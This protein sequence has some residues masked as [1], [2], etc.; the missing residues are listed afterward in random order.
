VR[1]KYCVRRLTHDAIRMTQMHETIY[2]IAGKES[3]LVNAECQRLLEQLLEPQQRL[4]GLFTADPAATPASEVLD[5][6]RTAPFLTDKR[7]VLIKN[8]D[9]FISNNRLLLEKYF[10]KPCPT[11]ILILTVNTWPANT[12]LAKRLSKVGKLIS[13]SQPKP[14]QLP[15]RLIEYTKDAHGKKLNK[16][17]AELLIELIGDELPRLYSEVDKLALF[18]QDEMVLSVS[19]VESLIGHSRIFGAFEVID[20]VTVGNIDKA[21]ARAR[22]MFAEDRS[23]E[24][25]VVGAFA[26]HLRRMFEAKALLEKGIGVDEIAKRMR[27]WKDKDSFF[28]QV[29]KMSLNQIGSILQRLAAID[30]QIKTGQTKA[31]VAMEQLVLNLLSG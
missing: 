3:C 24:Y 10:D 20:A 15:D 8:A 28:S 25:T 2:V 6:L 22:A 17:T 9:D 1:T 7:V 27:I 18:A 19:H 14:W 30:F 13:V 26:F 5:E 23:A 16:E 21:V 11:G 12:K 31:P 29:S 4:T